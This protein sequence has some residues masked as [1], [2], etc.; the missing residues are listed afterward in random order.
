MKKHSFKKKKLVTFLCVALGTSGLITSF[1]NDR[2][3]KFQT[4]QTES[5]KDVSWLDGFIVRDEELVNSN[6]NLRAENFLFNY[7]SGDK[8]PKGAV[9]ATAYNSAQEAKTA[10][11]TK[12]LSEALE[13]LKTINSYYARCTEGINEINKKINQ[14]I[15]RLVGSDLNLIQKNDLNWELWRLLNKKDVILG[16]ISHSELKLNK[17]EDE[18][19]SS[20]EPEAALS[21]SSDCSG[22]FVRY[23]DGFENL[24]NYNNLS[25]MASFESINL[26]SPESFK[27]RPLGKI[28]KSPTWHIVFDISDLEAEKIKKA[29]II[30]VSIEGVDWVKRVPAQVETLSCQAENTNRFK[31]VLS[32][33]I[34]NKNIASLRKE[35]FKVNTGEYY[36]IKINKSAVHT[37]RN[38][39]GVYVKYGKHLKFKNI[40]IIFADE[41]FVICGYRPEHYSDENYIQPGDKVVYRGKNLFEGKRV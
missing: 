14:T 30:N 3:V 8:I 39:L 35:K 28:V 27:V 20:S 7:S 16:K 26:I 2:K 1:V 40:D 22:E 38:S 34:M 10:T 29:Q 6:S 31:L 24:V 9:I 18:L 37:K 25:D 5:Y 11:K 36:G 12:K 32:C 41:Q 21:I 19:K 15:Q 33:D 23:T 4:V 13:K 17:L